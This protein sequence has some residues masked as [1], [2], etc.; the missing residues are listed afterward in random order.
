MEKAQILIVENDRI[1]AKDIENSL[2]DLGF[3]VCA[4]VPSGEEAL[5]ETEGQRPDLVL[6]DIML[7]GEMNGIEAA[8]Q[9]RSRFDIPVV[10]LTAYADEEILEKAKVTEPFGYII[11]PFKERELNTAIEIALYKHK[12]EKKLKK[13]ETFLNTTGQIAKVGGWEID[14]KTRKVFWTKEIYNITEAPNDYDPSSLEKEAI[15]FFS[16]EDQLRLQ[17][18]I[19]RA[20]EHNEPYNMEL[21]VTTAKG[22]KKWV[23]AICKPIVVDGKVVKLGGTFQDITD[24]K[25]TEE[26]LQESENKYRSLVESTEDSIYLVDMDCTYLF[27]NKKHLSRFGMKKDK[28]MTTF[29]PKRRQRSLKAG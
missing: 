3:D 26:A 5:E 1:V 25:Q 18:A 27:M 12:M 29:I 23:H 11:K 16:A 10:Y 6:M 21:Q 20:F 14:G 28:G 19:Q 2:K 15:V 9:I 4:S 13:S 17:I 7:E 8:G 22:N 24:R